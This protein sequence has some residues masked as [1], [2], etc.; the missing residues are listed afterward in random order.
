MILKVTQNIL[1]KNWNKLIDRRQ[2]AITT[3]DHK[4]KLAYFPLGTSLSNVILKRK[5]SIRILDS[6]VLTIWIHSTKGSRPPWH[7]SNSFEGKNL[8]IKTQIL[9]HLWKCIILNWDKFR[10]N[11]TKLQA[12]KLMRPRRRN[13]LVPSVLFFQYFS[14]SLQAGSYNHLWYCNY[15]V[16]K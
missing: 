3:S 7:F 5:S 10:V 8:H 16:M 14:V 9:Y 6:S 2:I 12:L 11:H 13:K 15:L 1:K 4:A